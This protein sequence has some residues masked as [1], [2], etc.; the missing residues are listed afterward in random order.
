MNIMNLKRIA[1]YFTQVSPYIFVTCFIVLGWMTPD[2]NQLKHTIS[3]L[4]LGVYGPLESLNIFQLSLGVFVMMYL[5]RH[6]VK[7]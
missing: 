6:Q 1:I 5:I 7:K 3:R 4:S 2:Y